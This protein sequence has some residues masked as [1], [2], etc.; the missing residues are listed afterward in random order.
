MN[1]HIDQQCV[2]CIKPDKQVNDEFD[3]ITL[4]PVC[5]EHLAKILNNLWKLTGVLND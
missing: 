2:L 3:I 1:E 5:A 4:G